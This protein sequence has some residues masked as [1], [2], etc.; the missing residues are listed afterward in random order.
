MDKSLIKWIIIEVV[1]VKAIS[2][3][4]IGYCIGCIMMI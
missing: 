1:V 4:F 3:S 2:I